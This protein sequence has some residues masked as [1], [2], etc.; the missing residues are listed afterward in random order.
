MTSVAQIRDQHKVIIYYL[1]FNT[2]CTKLLSSVN[3]FISY[4]KVLIGSS[5]IYDYHQK[6]V[7]EFF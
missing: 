2:D 4:V 3:I 7:Q 6:M 1:I 5:S